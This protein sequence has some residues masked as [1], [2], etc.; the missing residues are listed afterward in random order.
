MWELDYKE[1]WAP[2]NWC[3]WPV[4]LEKTLESPLDRKEIQPVHPLG[5]RSWVFIGRTDAEAETPILWPSHAKNWLIGKDPT[6]G[7]DWGQEEKGQQRMRWLDGITDSMDMGLGKLWELVM[8][9]EAWGAA[10]HGV[11]K[12]WTWLSDWAE[13]NSVYLYSCCC[14][15][16]K[17][18]PTL[19]SPMDCNPSD[20]SAHGILQERILDGLPSFSPGDLSDQGIEPMS[21]VL[22]GRF[23][24]TEPWV[25]SLTFLLLVYELLRI[26]SWNW[27]SN[28]LATSCKELT[29][30][31]IPWCWEGLGAGGEEDDRGWDGWMA[32]S[33]RWTWVWVNS[34]SWWWTG[35]PGMLQFMGSQRVGHNW[36]TELNQ[37]EEYFA[38]MYL[39]FTI[40][41]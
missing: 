35:R 9:R 15:V 3:F 26:F 27:N 21:P 8:D 38:A 28:T 39:C 20:S 10:I 23:F 37:T 13:M 14:L 29:H 31:K 7:R 40:L 18:W 19:C 12:S 33:T 1:S 36:A 4:V 2:K 6:A 41:D 34:G 25:K 32:S 24:T 11:A 17:S 30:W 5:D 16:T 22:A